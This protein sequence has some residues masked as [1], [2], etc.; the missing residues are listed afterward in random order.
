MLTSRT[1]PT[2]RAS[3]GLLAA[4]LAGPLPGQ[5][6]GPL[7]EQIAVLNQQLVRAP[8]AGEL[9]L[10]RGDLY[11]R[12]RDWSRALADFTTAERL[13]PQLW[14]VDYLRGKLFLD[15]GQPASAEQAFTRLLTRLPETEAHQALRAA[16]HLLLGETLVV[17]ARPVAAAIQ[18]DE[19]IARLPVLRPEV[20]VARA[21]A[22]ALAGPQ[23]FDLAL[24]GLDQGIAQLGPL[25]VLVELAL[26]L[27]VERAAWDRALERIA[28]LLATTPR[29]EGWL[30][31]KGEILDL[32]GRSQE[33]LLAF[34]AA[35]AACREVPASRRQAPAQQELEARIRAG[36]ARL[37][38]GP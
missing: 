26:E 24:S 5:A 30:T 32:A 25:P 14:E 7:H 20:F 28:Q 27:E 23:Y 35:W 15:A 31:R 10:A 33:A 21:Q 38:P 16:A 4:I 9:F 12:D 11:R 18:F 17:Q 1:L 19:A 3:L 8:Q 22:L 13:D 2:E 36:L 6:H 29:Q 34:Q 37:D